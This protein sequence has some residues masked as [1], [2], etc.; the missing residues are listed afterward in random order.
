[1]GKPFSINLLSADFYSK[2][3]LAK[4]PEMEYKQGRPYVV[5]LVDIDNNKFALPLRSNI[6]HN[7]CYKF[8]C[9]SR[10]TFSA[11]GIDFTKA[12]VVNDSSMIGLP[13]TMDK[14]E[15]IELSKKFYFIRQQ[16]KR[17]LAGYIAYRKS[18]GNA[19]E[20]TRKRYIHCTLQYF[21]NELGL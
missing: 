1:M 21:D 3:P 16:F 18:N 17:Y 5:M 8:K 11:T 19:N 2:F 7:F 6:R 12:V 4:Y 10:V 14:G 15:Y 9:S 20:H 13:A